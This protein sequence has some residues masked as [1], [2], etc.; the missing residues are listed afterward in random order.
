MIRDIRKIVSEKVKNAKTQNYCI[1]HEQPCT[2]TNNRRLNKLLEKELHCTLTDQQR[3]NK[4]TNQLKKLAGTA[5]EK[6]CDLN[7]EVVP[8]QLQNLFP[9]HI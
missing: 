2:A 8:R 5:I 1:H 9:P 6:D 4:V 7:N 3:A